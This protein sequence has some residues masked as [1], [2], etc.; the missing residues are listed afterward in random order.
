V[1]RRVEWTKG[2]LSQ[3]EKAIGHIAKD[4]APAADRLESNVFYHSDLLG[5]F[6]AIGRPGRAKGTRELVIH[7]NYLLIYKVTPQTIRIVRFLHARQ[8]YP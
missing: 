8:Q 5:E 7:P 2:A 3:L 1:Q 4:N 6:S